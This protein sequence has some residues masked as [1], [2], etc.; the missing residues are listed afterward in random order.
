MKN[1]NAR[2]LEALL[3]AGVIA[4]GSA[5]LD[6]DLTSFDLD[7]MRGKVGM[8]CGEWP[9]ALTTLAAYLVHEIQRDREAA[10]WVTDSARLPHAPD[11]LDVGIDLDAMPIL[12][13]CD[14]RDGAHASMMALASGAF[15]GLIWD[16]DAPQKL[17]RGTL[18]ALG[19]LARRHDAAV[20]FLCHCQKPP[21]VE[22]DWSAQVRMRGVV[23]GASSAS[24]FDR[25][26]LELMSN[27][28]QRLREH[29]HLDQPCGDA[30]RE[31]Y[32]RL[33]DED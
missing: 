20:L 32:L 7:F 5:L 21:P 12:R 19:M 17:T 28:R 27:R 13:L 4:R 1:K 2:S 31:V 14:A 26:E 29:R 11:L 22:A 23:S 24:V 30:S 8:F 9:S 33:F 3:D 18:T 15:G 10:V 16:L 25:V 6:E